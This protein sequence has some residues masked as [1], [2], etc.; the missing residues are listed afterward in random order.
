MSVAKS[1]GGLVVVMPIPK[2]CLGAPLSAVQRRATGALLHIGRDTYE[3]ADIGYFYPDP[4]S[5]AEYVI[6]LT[7]VA[8]RNDYPYCLP[9]R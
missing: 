3:I 1:A 2:C 7:H 9:T 8:Y 5:V 4:K 6:A